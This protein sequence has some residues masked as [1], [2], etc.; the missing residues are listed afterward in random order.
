LSRLFGKKAVPQKPRQEKVASLDTLS[1]EAL[2]TIALGESK[3]EGGE[4]MRLSAIQKV[5][6]EQTL[7]KIAFGGASQPAQRAAKKQLAALIDSDHLSFEHLRANVAEPLALFEIMSLSQHPE[8]LEQLLAAET[9]ADLLFNV[10]LK[11]GTVKLRQIAAQKITDKD[12]LTQLLK[13]SKGKD[14][15]VY[16]IV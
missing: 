16:K 8:K 4:Q 10:A 1:P 9:N 13:D 2:I 5:N 11:G 15:T 12:H 7:R 14:K 6:D 3:A